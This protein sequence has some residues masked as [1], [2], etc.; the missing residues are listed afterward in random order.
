MPTTRPP[1]RAN[2]TCCD[3][4]NDRRS[5]SGERPLSKRSAAR[6]AFA[7]AQSIPSSELSKLTATRPRLQSA[8]GQGLRL[9]ARGAP[10][11][12]RRLGRRLR[13]VRRGAAVVRG[14]RGR[15]ARCVPAVRRDA[16]SPLPGCNAPISSIAAVDCEE[17][18][19][20]AAQGRALRLADP[21]PR[22]Q[23]LGDPLPPSANCGDM[24]SPS[25]SACS[26][27]CSSAPA[28]AACRQRPDEPD[29]P[30][31]VGALRV[32]EQVNSLERDLGGIGDDR[33]LVPV[34][35]L[36][37]A[38]KRLHRRLAAPRCRRTRSARTTSGRRSR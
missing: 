16:S 18:G 3:C 15:A 13:P 24:R 30:A 38:R 11:G 27:S 2:A 29:A 37:P 8:R 23:L 6:S 33:V 4:S 32:G 25:V 36:R 31:V 28:G 34:G 12:A 21:P 10:E 14:V 22:K 1:S 19:A 17:C 20:R 26:P 35:P 9:A 5:A 7:C